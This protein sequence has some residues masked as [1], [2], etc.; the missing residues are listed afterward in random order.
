MHSKRDLTIPRLTDPSPPVRS[1]M[2]VFHGAVHGEHT[3]TPGQNLLDHLSVAGQ[4]PDLGLSSSAR[5]VEQITGRA[6][7]NTDCIHS[8]YSHVSKETPM[9]TAHVPAQSRRV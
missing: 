3:L 7:S 5:V 6:Y 2:A 9:M 8:Q 1:D 4:I